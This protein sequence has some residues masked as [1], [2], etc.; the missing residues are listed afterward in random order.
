MGAIRSFGGVRSVSCTRTNAS[1]I[2]WLG[3]FRTRK[4]VR[5]SHNISMKRE[6]PLLEWPVGGSEVAALARGLDADSSPL[7]AASTWPKALRTTLEL[8]LPTHAQMVL[9]WS[10]DLVAFYNDA[11]APTIGFKHPAA[12]GKPVAENWAEASGYVEHD[13]VEFR[14]RRFDG[15]PRWH[16]VRAHPVQDSEARKGIGDDDAAPMRWI[17]TNTDINDQK[18]AQQRRALTT[19]IQ[20]LLAF[21]PRQ[22]LDPRADLVDQPCDAARIR[23]AASRRPGCRR[24]HRHFSGR[25]R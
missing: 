5:S 11:Y 15:D 9:F 1:R 18:E 13:T 3:L 14:L 6:S 21:S 16:L 4:H 25:H 22:T 2:L 8:M 17:G 10:F 23:N 19:L 7:G 20:R 24:L 12:F